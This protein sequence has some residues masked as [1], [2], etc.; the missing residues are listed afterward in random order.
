MR[1]HKIILYFLLIFIRHALTNLILKKKNYNSDYSQSTNVHGITNM[2]YDRK[3]G[4]LEI[5][6]I[7]FSFFWEIRLCTFIYFFCIY[8]SIK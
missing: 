2:K 6:G 5:K 4:K 1:F 8:K 7:I 3:V